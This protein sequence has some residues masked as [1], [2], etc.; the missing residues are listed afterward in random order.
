MIAIK[1]IKLI[2]AEQKKKRRGFI[3]LNNKDAK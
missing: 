3:N 1:K 2:L